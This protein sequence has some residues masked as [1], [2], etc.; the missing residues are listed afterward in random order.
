MKEGEDPRTSPS[1]ERIRPEG[2]ATL[3][4]MLSGETTVTA[5]ENKEIV[6]IILHKKELHLSS[7]T[8]PEI[9]GI[10][11]SAIETMKNLDRKEREHPGSVTKEQRDWNLEQQEYCI[12]AIAGAAVARGDLDKG[13]R[14]L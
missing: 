5:E 1:P 13:M 10:L 9:N 14:E 7:L 3:T 8:R 2:R 11:Y 6:Q 4:D 12:K